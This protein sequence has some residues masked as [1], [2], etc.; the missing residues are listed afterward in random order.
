M[1]EL[2]SEYPDVELSHQFVDSAAMDLIVN[3][4]R[5][6][7]IVT[8]NMFGDILTDEASVITGSLGLLPSA[9][10]GLK[11]SL[12]EPIHG[13]FPQA[14][15]KGIANPIATIA[16]AAMLLEDAF[17]MKAEAKA[18]RDAI[19]QSMKA[20]KFTPDLAPE[21]AVSTQVL[22]DFIAETILTSVNS[23]A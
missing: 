5:F 22:G 4:T 1:Q 10:I 21:G 11:T 18:I 13:S 9:S 23:P 17:D 8:E 6:D 2:A 20:G 19:E 7:V 3:P 15:G 12:F 16:S 14:K